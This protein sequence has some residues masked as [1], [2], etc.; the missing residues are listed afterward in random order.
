VNLLLVSS[1]KQ[2]EIVAPSDTVALDCEMVGMG[3]PGT[4]NGLARCSI[5]GYYGNM[6][7]DQCIQPEGTITAFRTSVSESDME[8]ATPFPVAR[9]QILQLLRR[10]LVVGHDLRH[11]FE[12]LKENMGHYRVYGTSWDWLLRQKNGR[13][14]PGVSPSRPFPFLFHRNLNVGEVR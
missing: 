4:E 11:D 9:E 3:P 7:Y 1:L 13:E 10:K 12:A 2:P 14:T 8:G 5:V 6:V